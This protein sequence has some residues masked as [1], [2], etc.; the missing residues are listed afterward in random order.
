MAQKGHNVREALNKSW[1][2][3]F[4]VAPLMHIIYNPVMSPGKQDVRTFLA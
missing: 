3:Q 4:P 2:W 1:P